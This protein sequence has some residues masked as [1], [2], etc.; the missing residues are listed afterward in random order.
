MFTS[1]YMD[2]NKYDITLLDDDITISSQYLFYETAGNGAFEGMQCE[3]MSDS[4][5]YN[6]VLKLCQSIY[7]QIIELNKLATISK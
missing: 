3:Y 6:E 1:K 2:I 4:E 7:K 5:R